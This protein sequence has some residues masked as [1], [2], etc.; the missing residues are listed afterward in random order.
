LF[1]SILQ[2]CK[3]RSLHKLHGFSAVAAGISHIFLNG[4][5][6]R[7]LGLRY[8]TSYGFLKGAAPIVEHRAEEA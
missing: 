6:V 7:L 3:C 8:F 2:A 4:L 5:F 1:L